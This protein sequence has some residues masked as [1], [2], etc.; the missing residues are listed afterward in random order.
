MRIYFII[1]TVHLGR[2][3]AHSLKSHAC[4]GSFLLQL[5]FLCLGQWGTQNLAWK[6][7]KESTQTR[8]STTLRVLVRQ[9][10]DMLKP[11]HWSKT[12][13]S[14]HLYKPITGITQCFL[15]QYQFLLIQQIVSS[16]LQPES[17]QSMMAL[18]LVPILLWN[19]F[20]LTVPKSGPQRSS[21]SSRKAERSF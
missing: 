1:E 3:G 15:L 8:Y 2:V 9:Q 12:S 13:P 14:A 10:G 17:F 21:F 18:L 20:N 5:L 19:L 4:H 16:L 7:Q 11:T 6:S